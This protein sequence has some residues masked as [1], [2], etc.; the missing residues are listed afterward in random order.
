LKAAADIL[1]FLTENKISD[2]EGLERKVSSM[3]GEIQTIRDEL[4]PVERRIGTL[5]KHVEQAEIYRTHKAVHDKYRQEQNPKR[6]D[7][8]YQKHTA[9]IIRFEAADRYLNGVLNGCTTIPVKA[10]KTERAEKIAERERLT[11]KYDRLKGETRKVE[12]IKRSVEDMLR[13]DE[14]E[15]APMRA[16]G[17]DIW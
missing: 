2:M 4:K 12:Q 17:V 14:R 5:D 11:R 16:R 10:W 6:R 15:R 3:H 13:G 9:G 1:N 8:F 7:A